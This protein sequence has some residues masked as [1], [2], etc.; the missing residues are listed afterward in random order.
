MGQEGMV[1]AR[2]SGRPILGELIVRAADLPTR[3]EQ[4]QARYNVITP[5]VQISS[6]AADHAVNLCEVRIDAAVDDKGVGGMVYRD[7][8]FMKNDNQ[9]ALGKIALDMI[10]AAAGVSWLPHPHSRR[11]DD[12]RTLNL[13]GFTVVGAYLAMDGMVQ[14]LPPGSAEVDLRDGSPQIGGWTPE[15]WKAAT[16]AG[17]NN[18]NGWSEA[19]VLQARRF[20]QALAETK[21]RLRA[22]RSLGLKQV[23]TVEELA[24]PFIIPRVSFTPDMSNPTVAAV[25][26]EQRMAG[27]AALY[28]RQAAGQLAEPDPI[29]V[30][31]DPIPA[32]AA[33]STPVTPATAPSTHVAPPPRPPRLTTSR[34]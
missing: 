11:T 27:I 12:G 3:I 15:K 1:L 18:V 9:R 33:G 13:W 6:L 5:I 32:A 4:L 23:Y 21:A 8:S 14:T 10:A 34:T 16:A 29:T 17:R 26:T 30:R 7:K 2:E 19:R 25:V 24:R 28:G 31:P 20:G 22:I